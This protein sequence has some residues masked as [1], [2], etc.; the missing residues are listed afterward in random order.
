[1]YAQQEAVKL[2]D[3]GERNGGEQA[4]KS[5]SQ[6]SYGSVGD[7]SDDNGG[8]TYETR[9]SFGLDEDHQAKISA[10]ELTAL[11]TVI[12]ILNLL[13]GGP[14]A[15]GGPIGLEFCGE[16]CFW[17]TEGVIFCVIIAFAFWARMGILQRIRSG[18]PVLSEIEWDEDNTIR[19]PLYA[20]V[21]GL[22][23]GMFGVGGG[24]IKGPLMLALGKN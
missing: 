23:A 14:T 15:G 5:N 1:M 13:K 7:D 21:A 11:F 2:T 24:I 22:V 9:L 20:I 19:Y 6:T 16:A 3:N 8:S 12:T 17:V 10:A 18:G 4:T